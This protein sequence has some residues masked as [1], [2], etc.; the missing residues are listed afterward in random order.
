[1]LDQ[2]VIQCLEYERLLDVCQLAPE[3]PIGYLLSLNVREPSRLKVNFLS[4]EQ[5]RID[6]SFIL[7]AHHR[8]LQVYAWTVNIAEDM[9]HLFDLGVDG[10]ITDQSALARRTLDAFANR[11]KPERAVWRLSGGCFSCGVFSLVHACPFMWAS[12]WLP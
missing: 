1:M 8:G 5:K 12:A 3:V 6:H 7:R 4:V 10:I 2:V 11:P 9:E